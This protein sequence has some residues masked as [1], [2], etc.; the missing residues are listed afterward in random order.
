MDLP[1]P[2]GPARRTAGIL[3]EGEPDLAFGKVGVVCATVLGAVAD[4]NFEI[5]FE[6]CRFGCVF[7]GIRVA[8]WRAAGFLHPDFERGLQLLFETRVGATPLA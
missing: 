8:Y 3:V 4:D 1:E 7:V 6:A 2:G 5:H